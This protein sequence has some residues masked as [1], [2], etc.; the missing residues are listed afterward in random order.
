MSDY[1]KKGFEKNFKLAVP[2]FNELIAHFDHKSKI[3]QP[4]KIVFIWKNKLWKFEMYKSQYYIDLWKNHFIE[5]FN[6]GE[7]DCNGYWKKYKERNGNNVKFLDDVIYKIPLCSS[8]SN[9]FY[10]YSPELHKFYKTSEA[11]GIGNQYG[12]MLVP[13]PIKSN[14]KIITFP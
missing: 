9:D 6:T 12:F 8:Y 10:E 2:N 7:F 11:Y 1:T 5:F 14:E 4:S 13:K 3:H